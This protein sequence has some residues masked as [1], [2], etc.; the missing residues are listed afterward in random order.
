MNIDEKT[1]VTPGEWVHWINQDGYDSI[2]TKKGEL[3][4]DQLQYEDALL[5]S[6]AKAMRDALIEIVKDRI[7]SYR[8]PVL[9]N[10]T[11]EEYYTDDIKVIEQ[12]TGLT[13]DEI[14][15]ETK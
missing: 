15:K 6:S 3:I 8:Y 1:G 4:A 9:N 7:H 10:A 11:A 14:T 2:L 13:W 12:A 5:L